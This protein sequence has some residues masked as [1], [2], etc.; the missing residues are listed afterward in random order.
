MVYRKGFESLFLDYESDV[1][2]IHYM[3]KVIYYN[4]SITLGLESTL[5][6]FVKDRVIIAVPL[7][8]KSVR[9]RQDSENSTNHHYI[10]NNNI[11]NNIEYIVIIFKKKKKT[12]I[13]IDILTIDSRI[14]ISI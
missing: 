1:F 12:V 5:L 3:G 10:R 4:Y 8:Q 2:S 6:L 9:P 13:K 11:I 7:N 14:R